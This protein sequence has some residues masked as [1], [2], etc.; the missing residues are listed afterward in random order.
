MPSI[1]LQL[2]YTAA[3]AQLLTIPV[4][5]GGVLSTLAV[6]WLADGRQRRWP[7]IVMPYAVSLVGAIGLLAIPHPRFPGLTY[8]FLFTIPAGVYPAVIS[9]VSWTCNNLAPSWKRATG[10]AM[11]ITLGNLGGVIGSNIYLGREAPHYRTG[12]GVSAGCL[13]LAIVSTLV[14]RFAYDMENKRRDKM[15]EEEI[16]ARYTERKIPRKRVNVTSSRMYA[17]WL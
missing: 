11:N 16:R 5:A 2:G 9:L 3:K 12:Y 7:F 10:I 8:A 1:I 14:L 15:S 17:D 13:V 6:S 4:Y